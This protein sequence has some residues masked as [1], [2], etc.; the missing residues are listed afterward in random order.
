MNRYSDHF[1]VTFSD[2]CYETT[3]RASFVRFIQD[4]LGVRSLARIPDA[5]ANRHR[6]AEAWNALLDDQAS[7]AHFN[8]LGDFFAQAF[9]R[10]TM[11]ELL[12]D[13]EYDEGVGRDRNYIEPLCWDATD[14]DYNE[15]IDREVN[16]GSLSWRD[17]CGVY[18][19]NITG[20]RIYLEFENWMPKVGRVDHW[21]LVP[22]DPVPDP[23]VDEGVLPAPSGHLLV[24]DCFRI[25]EFDALLSADSPRSEAEQRQIIQCRTKHGLMMIPTPNSASQ[26]IPTLTGLS[27]ADVVDNALG[28]K[29]RARSL[30]RVCMDDR[31]F[32][33]CVGAIDRQVLVNALSQVMPPDKAESK[34]CKLVASGSVTEA[35]VPPGTYHFYFCLRDD[36]LEQFDAAGVAREGVSALRAVISRT[37]LTWTRRDGLRAS[38]EGPEAVEPD[39]PT[40]VPRA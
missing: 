29:L 5:D 31:A 1:F 19:C 18:R 33:G 4:L 39:A 21:R 8:L 35:Q 30:G 6:V 26:V 14:S 15:I 3:L 17:N 37:P 24:T 38:A 34:V 10:R 2:Y 25:E 22:L 16:A 12:N 20:E 9:H 7:D 13:T 11:S 32:T 23:L 28:D 36:S 40:D 27:I